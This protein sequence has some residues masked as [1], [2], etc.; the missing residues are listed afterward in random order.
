M[1]LVR[2]VVVHGFA[3]IELVLVGRILLDLGIIHAEG[4]IAD[5][6]APLSDALAALCARTDSRNGSP[7]GGT[8]VR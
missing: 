1:R 8:K 3:V 7:K 6:L 2:R 5:L 4:A